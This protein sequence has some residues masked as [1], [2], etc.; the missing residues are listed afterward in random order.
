VAASNLAQQV[1]P[2]KH[3]AKKGDDKSFKDIERS[4]T[5]QKAGAKKPNQ[6]C[7][8]LKKRRHAAA[9]CGST[10]A[11]YGG[12]R[13]P[14]SGILLLHVRDEQPVKTRRA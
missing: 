5:E 14:R 7:S 2:N 3:V 11:L 6:S 12:Q 13:T 10:S 4:N 8:I 9:Q 1:A